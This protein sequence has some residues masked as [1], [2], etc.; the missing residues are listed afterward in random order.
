MRNIPSKNLSN[1]SIFLVNTQISI[2][3]RNV[4][5]S[6]IFP[7]HVIKLEEDR[8]NNNTKK[9]RKSIIHSK[10]KI[11]LYNLLYHFFSLIHKNGKLVGNNPI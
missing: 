11:K 5:L 3:G 9:K 1:C 7:S 4:N 2:R 6:G 10:E 8:L